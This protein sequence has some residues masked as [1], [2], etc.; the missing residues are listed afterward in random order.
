M[1]T[2]PSFGSKRELRAAVVAGV[3]VEVFEPSSVPARTDGL[4]FLEGPAPDQPTR[5][6]AQALVEDAR[7]T[8][9]VK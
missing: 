6:Y 3:T 7:I 9:L 5:W 8:T 2:I 1:F 4:V